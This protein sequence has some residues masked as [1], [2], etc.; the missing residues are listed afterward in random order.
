MSETT[1]TQ[2]SYNE[3]LEFNSKELERLKKENQRLR[4]ALMELE[5]EKVKLAQSY[6]TTSLNIRAILNNESQQ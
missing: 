6:L 4:A 3:D 1:P 5:S 2:L